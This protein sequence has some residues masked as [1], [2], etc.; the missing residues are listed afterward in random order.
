MS[1]RV[2]VRWIPMPDAAAEDAS[3]HDLMPLLGETERSRYAGTAD[4][5]A[6]A[7]FVVGR[8]AVRALAAELV[9][10]TVSPA[11]VRVHAV[12]AVCGG[13]HGRPRLDL[14]SPTGKGKGRPLNVS[15]AHCALGVAV[16]A[17]WHGPVGVDVEAADAP[18]ASLAAIGSLIPA[19]GRPGGGRNWEPIQH[20]TRVEAVVKADG[21][22]LLIDPADVAIVAQ[23]GAIEA[24][25]ATPG[26]DDRNGAAAGDGSQR[27]AIADLRLDPEVRASTALALRP[28]AKNKPAVPLVSWRRLELDD[29][30][31]L[32]LGSPV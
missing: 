8:A 11:Q 28:S 26:V 24:T 32:T 6:A 19:A 7:R 12:C 9:D 10:H 21:R 18:L 16:A 30:R 1:P 3:V 2:H 4:A 5:A 20:W 29:L 14:V 31:Q 25:L 17:A 13:P 15:I 27:F 23:G 22:G